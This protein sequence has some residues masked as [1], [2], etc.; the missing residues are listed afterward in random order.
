MRSPAFA[1]IHLDAQPA[2]RAAVR[3]ARAACVE[4]AMPGGQPVPAAL[5]SAR[6]SL[7]PFLL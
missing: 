2:L 3:R 4:A 7:S 5:S 1:S 6:R